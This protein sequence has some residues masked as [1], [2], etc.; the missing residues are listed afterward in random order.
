MPKTLFV[1]VYLDQ[2]LSRALDYSVPEEWQRGLE[3]GMRVE[4]PLRGKTVKGTIAGVKATA[5]VAGVRPILRILSPRGEL[6]E[7]QWKLA[8]WMASYYGTPLQ[9]V[10]K[11]FIPPHVRKE[12]KQK[13]KIFLSLA[14]SKEEGLEWCAK[15][16]AKSPGQ[17]E[18]LEQLLEKGK[19]SFLADLKVSRAAVESL[20]KKGLI[21]A[22]K[23]ASDEEMLLDAEFYPSG[24]KKLNEE[25]E[26]CFTALIHA[27][28]KNTFSAH[29]I[30]GITGSGKTEVYLQAIAA[31]LEQGKG[32][33]LLVPE[34][35]LTSQTIE[36]LRSRF[37]QKI[38]VLH[39]RRSMGERTSAWEDLREG[40]AQIVLGAR[41]AIFAP[42]RK[43]GVIIVDEEHD[44]SYKQSDEMPCYQGRDLAVMR[45]RLENAVVILGSA[46]PSIESRHNAEIGKYHL[47]VLTNRATKASLPQVKVIDM[48]RACEKQGGFTHFSEELLEGIRTRME[49]GEQ[50]LLFL[51]RRGYHRM[52]LCAA[53]REIAKCPHCDLSLTYH[54]EI[55][56]LKCHL[57]DF[58]QESLRTCP[59][60]KETGSLE[61]KGFGTEHVERSLHA[62]FPSVRTLRMDRDTTKTKES[63]ETLFK[64]FRAHKADVLIG[65]QMIA[66]GFHFPSVTLVGVLGIDASL[67]IPDFRAPEQ[68][69]QLLIQVAG[70]SGRS[71][72][73]G[74]VILQTYL[75]DHPVIR[76]AANQDY[77][78]FY[79]ETMAER[80]SFG[81]PP[82][83]HLVKILFS[84]KNSEEAAAA[85]ETARA[86]LAEVLPHVL[87]VAPAGHPKIKDV[88][89]FQFIVKTRKI[90]AIQ[91]QLALLAQPGV[92]IDVD[93]ISTFF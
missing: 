15:L 7:P 19:G 35:S 91:K 77:E 16:R 82:F 33:M 76:W 78:T 89:R 30:H 87:P 85:A 59:S 73:P 56:K 21:T 5:E 45:A 47:H 71:E 46:T 29:L 53:C 74:E 24:P 72:L 83:C 93:P 81:Y 25:Q 10:L 79:R 39:H 90:S 20:V 43:L 41:S 38:A 36:R 50:T 67:T 12:V 68:V 27:M 92:R 9:R 66:K 32:A 80:K 11:C 70:R 54:K 48:K 62:I 1:S 14:I 88:Y 22:K 28:E 55:H 17:A 75:P 2:N 51:N 52:Q 64:Q 44:G 34:V 6:S 13:E 86:A 26:K 58:T 8:E 60:C 3:T 40:R 84:S 69:F 37:A 23:M 61:F 57:C 4:V 49:K 18:V 63:H 65:T 31:A 42:I